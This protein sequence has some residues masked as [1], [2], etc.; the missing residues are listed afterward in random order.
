M[1]YDGAANSWSDLSA[2]PSAAL[3]LF[4]VGVWTGSQFVLWG[5]RP[6]SGVAPSAA[7]ERFRP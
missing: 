4:G 1:L 6:A 2:W 3:H 7:G 5:G